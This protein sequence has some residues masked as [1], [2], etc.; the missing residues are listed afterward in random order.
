[1]WTEFKIFPEHCTARRYPGLVRRS[2]QM[3]EAVLLDWVTGM[4]ARSYGSLLFAFLGMVAWGV[5]RIAI[6]SEYLGV[7]VNYSITRAH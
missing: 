7:F 6:Y 5:H 4:E 1:M 3:I 2:Y